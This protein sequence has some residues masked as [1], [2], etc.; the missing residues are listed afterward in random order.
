M[1]TPH[2]RKFKNFHLGCKICR[3]PQ[4][5]R[6]APVSAHLH[7]REFD[8]RS[9]YGYHCRLKELKMKRAFLV[10]I[11]LLSATAVFADANF[12][13]F[14][15][16]FSEFAQDLVNG[17]PMNT[18]N[19][20]QWSQAYIG[21][22][23]HFG[24]GLTVGATTLSAG[25]MK[26]MAD[27]LGVALPSDFSY[28]S[29]YGLPLPTYTID[30][31]LGGFVL[32]F[33]IGFKLGYIPPGTLQKMGLQA[34]LDYILVGIDARYALLKDEG[35][36]PAL[37]VGLGYSHMKASVG[38]PGILPGAITIASINDGT[39]AHDLA[40]SDPSL[41]MDWSTNVL[42]LKAEISKK[43]LFITPYLGVAASLSFGSSASGSVQS[44]MTYNSNPLSP[45]EIALINS[46]N[47]GI[48]LS[49]IGISVN[50]DN[51][52]GFDFRAFGG[53]SFNLFIFYLDLGAGYDFSTG[54]IGGSLNARIVL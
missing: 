33:D 30:A 52:T 24:L 50:A 18:S 29:K 47:P 19:G 32:P 11:V 6:N 44:T 43:L 4:W 15:S 36:S 28:V 10:M 7:G 21:Q 48:D 42:D 22:F 39:G 20:L 37:S 38:V 17:A 2:W 49:N 34:D 53:I 46:H 14:Q 3:K 41:Q 23:P 40:L 12:T 26:T 54:S 27:A 5:C 45:G 35:L 13:V 8:K 1:A 9:Q 31:R 51:G 16:G 25:A